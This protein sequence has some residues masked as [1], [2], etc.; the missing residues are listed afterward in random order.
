M[1]KPPAPPVT[2]AV[3]QIDARTVNVVVKEN[4]KVTHTIH[5]TVSEDGKTVTDTDDGVN[6]EGEK[7]HNVVVAEKQ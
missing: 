6:D 2:V 5:A 3:T 4:G 1:T 7:V